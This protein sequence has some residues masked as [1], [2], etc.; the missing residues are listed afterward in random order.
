MR[1]YDE[2]K[3]IEAVTTWLALGKIPMV[4]AVVDV[5]IPT[6]RAW[7]LQPW[8]KDL[9]E[10][11]QNESDQELDTKLSK[12]ID[13]SLDAVVERIEGGEFILDSKTGKVLRIPVKLKDVHK[14]A[15]DLVDKRNLIRGK[16][17]SRV[18]KTQS[19][20]ILLKLASQFADWVKINLKPEPRIV[21]G[22]VLAIHGERS[23][24]LQDRVQQ[25]PQSAETETQPSLTQPST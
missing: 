7:R 20:D 9:V 14:V 19:E 22:E 15:V 8:W 11:I 3:K 21:E 17:T 5:S 25:I 4:A 23:Q 16:P 6:L 24:G 1:H 2:K 12:I 10:Q 18:E 13:K